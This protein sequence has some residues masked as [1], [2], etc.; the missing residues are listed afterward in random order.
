MAIL[1]MD[2]NRKIAETFADEFLGLKRNHYNFIE[3][4]GSTASDEP[5][6]CTPVLY[7]CEIDSDSFYIRK[8]LPQENHKD[9][10]DDCAISVSNMS[11]CSE[12][13]AIRLIRPCIERK[14][15]RVFLLSFY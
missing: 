4:S 6:S 15:C 10:G 1:S 2:K 9:F 8:A 14:Q 12:N 7:L 5:K 11:V 3:K 13:R